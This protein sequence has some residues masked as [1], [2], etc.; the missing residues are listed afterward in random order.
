M[1]TPEEFK[2]KWNA[3]IESFEED[4]EIISIGKLVQCEHEELELL[5]IQSD[6]SNFLT[7]IGLPDSAAPFMSF[8]EIAR[9][10]L[11]KVYDVWG[12]KS[13][14]ST[15]D[16]S[17]LDNYL[18]IGSDGAGNPLVIDIKN[19]CKVLHLEHEDL[20]KTV[21]FVNSSVF[22]LAE[23]LLEVRSLIS[24]FN[25]LSLERD[26][27]DQIPARFKDAS[28]AKLK[29]ID[30]KA[31]VEGGVIPPFLTKIKSRGLCS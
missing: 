18:V 1:H 9:N 29:K 31:T 30:A 20:F 19:D 4:G 26:E 17:R 14:Y 23:F 28:I 10:G 12:T 24:E 15:E 2:V 8:E 27:N 11:S 16:I 5:G 3:G 13:D 21:T 22:N 25:R 6:L 7:N